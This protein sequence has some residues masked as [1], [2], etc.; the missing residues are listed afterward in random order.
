MSDTTTPADEVAR[1]HREFTETKAAIAADT[2]LSDE[3]RTARLAAVA[4][5]ANARIDKLRTDV[6]GG[7]A[8]ERSSLE[9][10]LLA[11]P[12]A[13][14]GASATDKIAHQASYRDAIAR[15]NMTTSPAEL[16]ELQR[17]AHLSGDSLLARATLL[18]GMSRGDADTVNGWSRANPADEELVDRLFTL[19]HSGDTRDKATLRSLQAA[20]AFG[21]VG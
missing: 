11:P 19:T 17:T 14:L 2:S 15:A 21:K 7:D 5:T 6:E 3:G 13:P 20:L 10:R 8:V 1:I 12:S 4:E 16:L 18:V 9:L